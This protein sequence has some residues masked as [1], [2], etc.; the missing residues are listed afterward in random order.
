MTEL[1]TKYWKC[2]NIR[3]MASAYNNLVGY[4]RGMK[5]SNFKKKISVGKGGET[6]KETLKKKELSSRSLLKNFSLSFLIFSKNY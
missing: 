2:E 4:G 3:R 1:R 6:G 5:D